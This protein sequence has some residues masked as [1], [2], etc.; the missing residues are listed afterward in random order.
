MENIENLKAKKFINFSTTW[1]NINKKTLSK[2][3]YAAY[4]KSFNC[5]IDYYKYNLPNVKFYNLIIG[6]TLGKNDYRKKL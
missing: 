3:S 1:E 6:D 5:I 2:K 4:K